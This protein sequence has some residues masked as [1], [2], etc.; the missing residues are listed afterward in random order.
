[1]LF[2][3]DSYICLSMTEFR[4]IRRFG[5][6]ATEEECLSILQ[7]APRGILSVIGENGY[8]YGLPIN[9]AF[10]DGK[11]FFHC[12]RE[13]HKLDAIRAHDK[14]CFTV[15][16][17]IVFGRIHEV[18]DPERAVSLLRALA[19]KYFPAD[20]DTEADIRR[21]GPKALLLEL[22]IDHMTGKH[23]REK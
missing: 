12:A 21:N 14:V 11:I 10:L 13:G 17:V 5:Q 1:M 6:A 19:T 23:V 4:P 20:Y 18:T 3:K 7:S 2:K 22:T 16:S 9:Y 15:R 8:P